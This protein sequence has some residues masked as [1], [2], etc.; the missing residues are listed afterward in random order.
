MSELPL[1]LAMISG[2]LPPRYARYLE[3]RPPKRLPPWPMTDA[4]RAVF[5]RLA[6]RPI[7]GCPSWAGAHLDYLSMSCDRLDAD[8]MYR[9][10]W[11]RLAFAPLI[12]SGYA[13]ATAH[14]IVRGAIRKGE[15]PGAVF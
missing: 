2:Q 8:V 12:P 3:L 9:L 4:D 11:V 14:G 6:H 10:T 15:D 5:L 13:R 1:P 7:G